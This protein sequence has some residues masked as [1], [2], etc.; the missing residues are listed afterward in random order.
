MAKLLDR[1]AHGWHVDDLEDGVDILLVDLPDEGDLRRQGVQGSEVD[2]GRAVAKE[3]GLVVQR[4][5]VV[6]GGFRGGLKIGLVRLVVGEVLRY[7]AQF[8]ELRHVNMCP[9]FSRAAGLP[10]R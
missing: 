7:F 1:L 5:L 9:G 10:H 8:F 4:A 3:E 2:V 6:V